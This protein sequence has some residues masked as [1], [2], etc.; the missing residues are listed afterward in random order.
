M[1]I[2]VTI[3]VGGAVSTDR[4]PT[5][6]LGQADTA[7]YAAKLNG[8]DQVVIHGV[9]ASRVLSADLSVPVDSVAGTA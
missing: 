8:R 4:E 5:E 2:S 1:H 6:A 7:L 3:S 9:A